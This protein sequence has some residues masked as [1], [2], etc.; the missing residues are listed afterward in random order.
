MI[1]NVFTPVDNI[2]NSSFNERVKKT[3]HVYIFFTIIFRTSN[4]PL[5]FDKSKILV[6]RLKIN[7]D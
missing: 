6:S 5:K 2:S 1:I 3:K 7:L 4:F